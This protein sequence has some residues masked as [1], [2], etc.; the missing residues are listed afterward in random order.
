MQ[1]RPVTNTTK[2]FQAERTPNLRSTQIAYG[3]R[4]SS[5]RAAERMVLVSQDGG[6]LL[7]L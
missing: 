6:A 4:V 3:S 2:R 5:N 1:F 7:S